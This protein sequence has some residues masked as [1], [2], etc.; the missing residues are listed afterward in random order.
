L[1]AQRRDIPRSRFG[2]VAIYERLADLELGYAEDVK[3][4]D[5]VIIGSDIPEASGVAN[6]VA[7]HTNGLT[8]FYDL[9]AW[10][11]RWARTGEET[12]FYYGVDP[13]IYF[14]KTE[15]FHWDLASVERDE[16]VQQDLTE[17]L[18][19]GS[20]RL[21]PEGRFAIAGQHFPSKPDWP[22]NVERLPYPEWNKRRD[23]Y[24]SQCYMLHCGAIP[25]SCLFEAAACATP[26][27]A[28]P[29]S[30][31]E[32]QFKPGVE[33]Y[34]AETAEDV[35]RIVRDTPYLKRGAVGW[36]ARQ[37][38]LREHVISHRAQILEKSVSDLLEGHKVAAD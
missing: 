17:N 10:S 20:A 15:V 29:S 23:F 26:V 8:A 7:S 38:V 19:F 28:F 14:P 12:A 32:R 13:L 9:E 33:I 11:L 22:Q 5:C 3:H 21:W 16:I 37:R 35:V 25:S 4:A 2:R 31:I 1:Y 18:L 6:W 27:V 36:A 24:N 30:E 34:F